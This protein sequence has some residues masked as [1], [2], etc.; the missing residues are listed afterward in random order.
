MQITEASGEIFVIIIDET[1]DTGD[2]DDWENLSKEYRRS[3]ESKFEVEFQETNV[4]AG[5]DI[6]AFLTIIA[7]T[8]IPIPL[9]VGLLSAFFLGKP[10][11]EN[12][13]GWS[14][15]GRRIHKFF[16]KPVLLS[17]HGAAILAVEAVFNEMGGL[18]KKIQLKNY[19]SGHIGDDPD[20]YEFSEGQEIA[21]SGPIINLGHTRHVFEIT[22]DGR[23]F[24]VSV[25]GRHARVINAKADPS[26]NVAQR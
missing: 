8:S 21:E 10:I 19:R 26:A 5:A 12:L 2:D 24:L 1:Y 17:R 16:Q 7:T 25:E 18:P 20:S 22:A 13:D 15:I 6:P 9:W 4:G 14:D 3:L 23:L 11:S